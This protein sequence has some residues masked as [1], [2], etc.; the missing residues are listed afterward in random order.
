MQ[1]INVEKIQ[2][3]NL[4]NFSIIMI[5]TTKILNILGI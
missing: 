2:A 3:I 1:N 4:K 5:L